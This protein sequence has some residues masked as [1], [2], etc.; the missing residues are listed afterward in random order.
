MPDP[1][2]SKRSPNDAAMFVGTSSLGMTM[3]SPYA[4]CA[5]MRITLRPTMIRP[6]CDSR[7]TWVC[8]PDVN[9]MWSGPNSAES[10]IPAP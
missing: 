5:L 8:V 9:A 1:G 6:I 4:P 10:G 7:T 3:R 2:L